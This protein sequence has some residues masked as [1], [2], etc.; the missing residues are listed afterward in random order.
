MKMKFKRNKIVEICETNNSVTEVHFKAN[1]VFEAEFFTNT[2]P[3]L[4]NLRFSDNSMAYS[5]LKS[6]VSVE[7]D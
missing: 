7:K 1:E 4:V 2:H 3:R 6:D 5:L